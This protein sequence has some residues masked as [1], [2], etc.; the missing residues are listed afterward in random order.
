M[1]SWAAADMLLSVRYLPTS[2]KSHE[3]V[4]RFAVYLPEE[5]TAQLSSPSCWDTEEPVSEMYLPMAQSLQTICPSSFWYLPPPH[6][7]QLEA[8]F[9][10]VYVPL[11]HCKQVDSALCRDLA[12]KTADKF[13]LYLPIAQFVQVV[14]ALRPRVYFPPGHTVQSESVLKPVPLGAYV[15]A[16]HI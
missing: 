15:P 1:A 10:A 13:S 14:A 12:V 7:S 8:P 3:I 9:R 6:I 16:G 4:P 2:H 5:H 11:A